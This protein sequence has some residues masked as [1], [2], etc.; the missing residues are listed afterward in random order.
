MVI[1]KWRVKVVY[2]YWTIVY[3]LP[4]EDFTYLKNIQLF[5]LAEI[6]PVV[7]TLRETPFSWG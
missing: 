7:I 5:P 4:Y 3:F 1:I 6:I 2:S